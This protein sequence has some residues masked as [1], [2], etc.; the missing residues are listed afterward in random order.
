MSICR[1]TKV[2]GTH[3]SIYKIC[4]CSMILGELGKGRFILV[5]LKYRKLIELRDNMFR[6]A[7]IF[8]KSFIGTNNTLHPL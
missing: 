2:K 6:F 7:P 5:L 8:P 3:K 1:L 4:D